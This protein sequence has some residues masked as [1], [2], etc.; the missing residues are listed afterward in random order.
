M[1][2]HHAQFRAHVEWVPHNANLDASLVQHLQY[3]WSLQ[4][5]MIERDIL[6][7]ILAKNKWMNV[8]QMLK[9]VHFPPSS[10]LPWSQNVTAETSQRNT[11]LSRDT[12]CV[13]GRTVVS[14]SSMFPW[15]KGGLRCVH[16]QKPH[17]S[18]SLTLQTQVDLPRSGERQHAGVR[19][20]TNCFQSA[21]CIWA[22]TCP[23]MKKLN[24]A[25]YREGVDGVGKDTS[26][27]EEEFTSGNMK[28]SN[29]PHFL[30]W[31]AA[32][33]QPLTYISPTQQ[34]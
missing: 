12:G 20:L 11:T 2:F 13:T 34:V 32:K 28:C 19:T 24:S 21:E 26:G 15:T 18:L 14:S 9:S 16:A 7:I 25:R 5:K 27:V 33:V 17:V 23:Q 31:A 3:G 6:F 29:C 8:F 1:A 22:E 10:Q 30:H 4:S